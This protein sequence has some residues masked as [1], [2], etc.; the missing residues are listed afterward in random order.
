MKD[1]SNVRHKRGDHQNRCQ[2]SRRAGLHIPIASISLAVL[3]FLSIIRLGKPVRQLSHVQRLVRSC[4][5][6]AA[7]LLVACDEGPTSPK[8][9]THPADGQLWAAIIVPEGTPDTRTWLPYIAQGRTEEGQSVVRSA[10]QLQGDAERLRRRG[11][12]E[13]AQRL[14]EE[15]AVLVAASLI[16]A[17]PPRVLLTGI[18]ALDEWADRA[19]TAALMGEFPELAE[20]LTNVI[21]L[22]DQAREALQ[23]G[24]TLAAVRDLTTAGGLIREHS[25]ALVAH[26]VLTRA[27]QRISGLADRDPD[28]ARALRLLRHSREALAQ[29]DAVRALRRA[30][31]ALQL[32]EGI[33]VAAEAASAD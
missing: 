2:A 12:A 25:P 15:A 18:A 29:G 26:R 27:E 1:Q 7:G 24:D 31:Y 33:A 3:T 5:L 8:V 17:P 23:L 13:T 32:A 14:E 19:R 21:A 30:L 11:E 20:R 16:Q 6:C 4:G 22:R 28:A 10:R 9:Y